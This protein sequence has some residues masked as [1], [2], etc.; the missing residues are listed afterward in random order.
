[1]GGPDRQAID[2]PD[3]LTSRVTM[4]LNRGVPWL[5]RQMIRPGTD[6]C[7]RLP[8][9]RSPEHPAVRPIT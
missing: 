1:M 6:I 8:A 7:V 2:A 3:S 4:V 9:R 5:S